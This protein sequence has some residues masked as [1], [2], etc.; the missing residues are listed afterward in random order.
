[1]L[2]EFLISFLRQS[3][4]HSTGVYNDT[5]CYSIDALNVKNNNKPQ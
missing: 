2:F 3:H 4:I 1:M 5:V